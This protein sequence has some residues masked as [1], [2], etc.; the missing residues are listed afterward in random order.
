MKPGVAFGDHIYKEKLKR[1]NHSDFF[2]KDYPVRGTWLLV[3]LLAGVFI[4]FGRLFYLQVIK[5]VYYRYLADGNRIKTVNIHAPRGI[6][7]DRNNVPLVFN[8]S[9]YRVTVDGKTR[10]LD[11]EEALEL[12]AKGEKN[13][14]TD[15]Q[16]LYPYKDVLSHVVGYIGQISEE[17]LKGSEFI[18]YKG[19]DLVGKLG[20]EQ[21]YEK[22]LKG[23][24]GKM[25]VEVD[26][27][28]KSIRKLGQTD[29]APGQNI[30]LTIDIELQKAAYS[31]MKDVEK[32]AVIVS[33]LNGEILALVSKPSFDPNLFTMG[34]N[35]KLPVDSTYSSLENILLDEANHP[36]L[37]RAIAGVYAPG[38]TFKLVVAAAGIEN[39]IIDED[40]IVEDTGVLRIKEFSFAN[41]YFTKY[42]K[43]D[44]LVNVV[45]GIKRSN[46]IFF[47]KLAEKIGVDNISKMAEK[48]GVGR[49]LGIDLIGEQEGTLPTTSWKKEV[50]GEQWYLGDTYH[51]GIG[52]GYLLVTPLQVNAW[53]QAIANEGMLYQ[54]HLLKN[55]K[56]EIRNPKGRQTSKQIQNTN[57]RNSKFLSE[58]TISLIR[59]GMI[60]SCQPGG[61]AWPL[62]KFKVK[63]SKLKVDGR[64]FLKVSEGSASA[65]LKD[66]REVVVACKTGTAEQGGEDVLPH[67]WITLFAGAFDPE[68][69]VTVLAESSGEGS[70]IAAPI[71]KKIL[72]AYFEKK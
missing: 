14:E 4:L 34:K 11:N 68:I 63:S 37:N 30:F 8:T 29:A 48:F 61:V 9:G 55:P 18:N 35:Y 16:R 57:D 53:T 50:I 27:V 33:A 44:G 32:G 21:R 69:V 66:Q 25:L 58:K 31:A 64:N 24:S 41:W 70:N 51:Y 17:E 71:A 1:Y 62:F 45:E 23:R 46:D 39:N 20:I 40:F 67:A 15:S 26:S 19:G 65:Q 2:G 28:G 47:Y 60:E 10:V 12:I 43:T 22:R 3:F 36:L 7:M 72:E 49:K 54:P 6:I 59:K 5:G 42:G 38:S 52:Q 56:S 13:I